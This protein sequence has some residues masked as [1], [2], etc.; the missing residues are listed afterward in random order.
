MGVLASNL[1]KGDCD[2][3]E[4]HFIGSFSSEKVNK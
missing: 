1:E 4:A 2:I 3:S